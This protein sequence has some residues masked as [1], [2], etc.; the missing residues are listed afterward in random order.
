[1]AR[2][3]A[4]LAGEAVVPAVTIPSPPA[5]AAVAIKEELVA[6]PTSTFIPR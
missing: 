5:Q 4:D 2:P 1:V 3:R 6:K